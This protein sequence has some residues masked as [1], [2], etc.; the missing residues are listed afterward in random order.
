MREKVR[1]S[2]C[3]EERNEQELTPVLKREP[4]DSD[5]TG[6]Q[7][8]WASKMRT[9]GPESGWRLKRNR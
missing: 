4:I 8:G 9:L 5:D 6:A 7:Y 1:I 2:D 3:S